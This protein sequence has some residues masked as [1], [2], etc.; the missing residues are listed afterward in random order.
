ML[1]ANTLKG[2][3]KV[4]YENYQIGT[5][6]NDWSDPKIAPVNQQESP[7]AKRQS[8][9]GISQL[10]IVPELSKTSIEINDIKQKVR[11]GQPLLTLKEIRNFRLPFHEALLLN[12]NEDGYIGAF[13]FIKEIL[14]LDEKWH[15]ARRG[16]KESGQRHRLKI[17]KPALTLLSEG[18]MEAEIANREYDTLKE[19]HRFLNLILKFKKMNN[20]SWA[21][22]CEE[23]FQQCVGIVDASE[24]SS[25]SQR[26]FEAVLKYLYSEFLLNVVNNN[27]HARTLVEESMKLSEHKPYSAGVHLGGTGDLLYLDSCLLLHQILL[28]ESKANRDIK[29]DY[30]IQL[31]KLSI[32]WA[33][34]ANNE[35]AEAESLL[36]LVDMYIVEK[37]LQYAPDVL[38]RYMKLCRKQNNSVHIC[39]GHMLTARYHELIQQYNLQEDDLQAVLKTATENNL[40]TI[41]ASAHF[42]LAKFYLNQDSV[43][44]AESHAVEAYHCYVKL[45]EKRDIKA[46][47]C[48]VGICQGRAIL[49]QYIE[50]LSD[51][52]SIGQYSLLPLIQWRTLHIPFFSHVQLLQH[53][54]RENASLQARMDDLIEEEVNEESIV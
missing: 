33:K 5:N 12:L 22:L 10:H 15:E 37:Y 42:E 11:E 6:F 35:V 34:V 39:E 50:L 51:A 45:G 7:S 24:S 30:A 17:N 52:V 2:S 16:R 3:L 32:H 28:S 49:P 9:Y 31:N 19:L 26:E 29:I 25:E 23:L 14:D 54:P 27:T 4:T 20:G 53:Q 40:S 13:H 47:S 36:N 18:L 44:R 1:S 43:E 46:V 48:L 38:E 41:I 21:W 8:K